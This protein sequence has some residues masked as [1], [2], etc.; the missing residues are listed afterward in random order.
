M[1]RL[2]SLIILWIFAISPVLGQLNTELLSNLP[3][4]PDLNDVWGYTD[5]DGTEYA[6]V[7]LRTGVSVST[8]SSRAER[9][10]EIPYLQRRLGNSINSDAG[11]GSDA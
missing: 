11:Q 5:D 9:S 4:G 1:D 7:G 2:F 10:H 3:Y 6:L 8:D